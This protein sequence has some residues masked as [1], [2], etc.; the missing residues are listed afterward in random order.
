MC[1]YWI[2]WVSD[3]RIRIYESDPRTKLSIRK[4]GGCLKIY[5]KLGLLDY[6]THV[7]FLCPPKYNEYPK[8]R[9][10]STKN[11]T[12]AQNLANTKTDI[13]I[14]KETQRTHQVSENQQISESWWV[15]AN[16]GGYPKICRFQSG[17]VLK[18]TESVTG[19]R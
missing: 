7:F 2:F 18:E 16:H 14:T 15:T 17:R 6:E 10:H 1:G 11:T 12:D 9:G 4:I 19:F 3:P 5:P 13:Q 8:L